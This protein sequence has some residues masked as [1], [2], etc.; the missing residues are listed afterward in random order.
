MLADDGMTAERWKTGSVVARRDDLETGSD[1]IACLS[2][3]RHTWR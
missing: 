2:D 3:P 1:V